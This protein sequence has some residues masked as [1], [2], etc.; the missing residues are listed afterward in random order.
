[1]GAGRVR[2]LQRFPR[3]NDLLRWATPGNWGAFATSDYVRLAVAPCPKLSEL[4]SI[5]GIPSLASDIVYQNISKVANMSSAR[6]APGDGVVRTAADLFMGRY[7]KSC[8]VYMMMAY[9][10]NYL[11]DYKRV[12][13]TFDIGDLLSGF[14]LFEDKWNTAVG[15]VEESRAWQ[16]RDHGSEVT[17]IPALRE[18]IRDAVS[19]YGVENYINEGTRPYIPDSEDPQTCKRPE[20]G[21]LIRFGYVTPDE[22]RQIAS[23]ADSTGTE[24]G[25]E[26]FKKTP[27][28]ILN[29]CAQ[30]S[31]GRV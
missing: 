25:D 8:T 15:K 27:P 17:G 6:Y 2:M 1:M 19:R 13:S 31:V 5:Y 30:K 11:T 20:Y 7:G 29:S 14:R 22:V 26:P 24:A 16:E 23:G 18:S 3:G 4:R 28:K 9:F 12:V 21:S 10:A